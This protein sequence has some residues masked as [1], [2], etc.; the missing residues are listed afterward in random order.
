MLLLIWWMS[1]VLRCLCL[2]SVTVINAIEWK[3]RYYS[4]KMTTWDVAATISRHEAG[5][6]EDQIIINGT[7]EQGWKQIMTFCTCRQVSQKAA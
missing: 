7:V 5:I 1:S 4:V 2:M 3:K 6:K